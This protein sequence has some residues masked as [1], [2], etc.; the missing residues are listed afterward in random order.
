MKLYTPMPAL[1]G[2][3]RIFNDRRM[4]KADAKPMLIYFWSMS[5]V[6]CKQSI[7]KL[8][9]IHARFD[10]RLAIHA[11]HMPRN[12]QDYSMEQLKETIHRLQLPFPVYADHELKISDAFENLIV[13]AYYLFD[14]QQRLRFLKYGFVSTKSL[15]QKIERII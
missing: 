14:E 5:C 2:A 13:P 15:Q 11:I 8:K 4:H 7:E 10:N 12:D 3:S 1:Q 6:Q 9:D